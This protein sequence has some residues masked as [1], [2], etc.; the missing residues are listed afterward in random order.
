MRPKES[1]IVID[2][3]VSRLLTQ[4]INDSPKSQSRIC[5]ELGLMKSNII[6]M[7]KQGRTDLPIE[8]VPAFARALDIPADEL[9]IAALKTKHPDAWREIACV[10]HE[11]LENGRHQEQ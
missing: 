9:M 8:R 4:A 5:G 6:T 10:I 1:S 7:F 3:P 2:T 11:A